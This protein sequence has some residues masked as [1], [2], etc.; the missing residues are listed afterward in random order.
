MSLP[1]ADFTVEERSL[2]R[3]AFLRLIPHSDEAAVRLYAPFGLT[4]EAAVED[5]LRCL[6][7]VADALESPERFAQAC[8]R[9]REW[10]RERCIVPDLGAAFVEILVALEQAPTVCEVSL[11]RRLWAAVAAA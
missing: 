10:H 3:A 2:L 4:D 11:W 8:Q 1:I 7:E 6:A 9:L 5:G